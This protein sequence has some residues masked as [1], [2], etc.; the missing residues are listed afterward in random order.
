MN[1]DAAP[2][3][4][5]QSDEVLAVVPSLRREGVMAS[6]LGVVIG[7]AAG[8]IGVGGGEFRIPVLIHLL[9]FPVKIAAGA[10]TVIGL[11]VVVTGAIRRWGQHQW[12]TDELTLAGIMA[13]VALPGSA[14]GAMFAGKIPSRPLKRFVC[15]YLVLVGAWMLIEA[16]THG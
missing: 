5:S 2:L 8:L 6:A 4:V 3:N 12:T 13:A 11:F 14:L 1:Q 15:G 10:N 9:R 7:V 16:I